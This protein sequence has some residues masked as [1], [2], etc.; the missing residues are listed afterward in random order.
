MI[1]NTMREVR[2]MEVASVM[3]FADG[4]P[5]QSRARHPGANCYG[6]E[7]QFDQPPPNTLP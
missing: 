1:D 4:R 6:L 5:G 7:Y 3:D 2:I